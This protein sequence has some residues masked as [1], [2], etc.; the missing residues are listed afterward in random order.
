[1]LRVI[2]Y[3]SRFESARGRFTSLPGWGRLLVGIFAL[4]GLILAGLSILALGVSILA[5]LL[6]TVPVYR[7]LVF[8]TG[9]GGKEMID[10]VVVQDQPPVT[11]FPAGD[12][13]RPRRKIDVKIVE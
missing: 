11:G 9:G 7:L 3:Y 6:L 2:Q 12:V 10:A 5:L 13:F 1:M 8:M 4:P